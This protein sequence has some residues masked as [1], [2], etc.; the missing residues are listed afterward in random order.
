MWALN[1]WAAAAGRMNPMSSPVATPSGSPISSGSAELNMISETTGERAIAEKG[2]VDVGSEGLPL[3]TR[4]QGNAE[5]DEPDVEKVLAEE[6]E[7]E[8]QEKGGH[9]GP[10]HLGPGEVVDQAG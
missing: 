9:R 10:G 6:A 2:G 8:H 3:E 1:S 7:A 4:I 5:D